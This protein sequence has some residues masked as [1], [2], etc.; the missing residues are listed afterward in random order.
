MLPLR[1]SMN[2][3][4][5]LVCLLTLAAS[6][7][8]YGKGGTNQVI[9]AAAEQGDVPLLKEEFATNAN[10]ALTLRDDLLRVAAGRGQKDAVDFLID[11]GANVNT[12]GFFDLSPLANMAMYGTTNDDKCAEVAAV[13]LARG[14]EVDPIDQYGDTP[15]FHAVEWNKVKLTR[16]LL[17]HGANPAVTRGPYFT[18]L[19]LAAR[20][21]HLEMVNLLLDFKAPTDI[22]DPNGNLP[23]LVWAIQMRNHE[24]ARMLIEHGATITPPRT[25]VP[26]S[27][28]MVN[29]NQHWGIQSFNQDQVPMLMALRMRDKEIIALLLHSTNAAPIDAVDENGDT[30]LHWAVRMQD[31]NI[32][33]MVLDAKARVDI[34]N[35]GGATPI[36]IAQ[37]MENDA[38]AEI[39]R[40]AAAA[41][42]VIVEE[43]SVPSR[44]EMRA[45]A[46]RICDGDSG[47]LDQLATAAGVVYRGNSRQQSRMR[48]GADRMNAAFS[49]LGEQAAKGNANAMEAL[50]T[51]LD[52]NLMKSFVPNALG[53]AA[54]AGNEEALSLLLRYR[55][56][57]FLENEAAFALAPAAKTNREPAVDFFVALATDPQSA[58]HQYYGVGWLVKEVLQTSVTNG[59]PRAKDALD[60]FLAASNN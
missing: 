51:C 24:L 43:I 40:K 2:A 32:V 27:P 7:P 20:G 13:L 3:R 31:T 16:V 17:E 49:V 1:N 21:H 53:I 22:K 15:L 55:D 45:I 28:N 54:A 26:Q 44:E 42:G 47:A 59:N 35:Y 9:F 46:Q 6:L 4:T 50:K 14:A 18:P 33:S 58:K 60:K 5:I 41:Q 34:T 56:W 11:Q 23:M 12:K 29:V 36:F 39:L 8:S 10:T 25:T 19:H 30:A 48:L 57:H 37:E 38:L 52:R